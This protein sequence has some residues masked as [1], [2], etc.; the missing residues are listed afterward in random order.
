MGCLLHG[1]VGG[2]S[3]RDTKRVRLKRVSRPQP[4]V[5]LLPKLGLVPGDD[6]FLR[7]SCPLFGSALPW[8][9]G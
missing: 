1:K 5:M 9:D 8:R 2:T 4:R 7:Q 3:D 6:S